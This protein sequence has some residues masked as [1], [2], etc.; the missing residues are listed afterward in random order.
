M[1]SQLLFAVMR[2]VGIKIDT[3]V[4]TILTFIDRNGKF[5]YRT[6]RQI[7]NA[8]GVPRKTQAVIKRHYVNRNAKN[9][10]LARMEPKITAHIFSPV[11]LVTQHLTHPFY[12]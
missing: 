5:I 8:H 7:M 1:R 12:G 9:V 11:A 2:G 10:R 3:Y 4:R 6:I